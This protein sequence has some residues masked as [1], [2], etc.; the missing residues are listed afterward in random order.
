MFKIV[1]EE[2]L[3]LEKEIQK[4]INQLIEENKSFVFKAGAGAG[5]TYAL[6]EALR[7]LLKIK[8]ESLQYCNQK[9]AV[10]TFTNIATDEIKE[11]IGSSNLLEISTIHNRLWEIIR[12]YKKELVTIHLG[13]LKTK[14]FE[15]EESINNEKIMVRLSLKK[16]EEFIH[17]MTE[18]SNRDIFY[19]HYD[20]L[21]APAK[22]AYHKLFAA[23][24]INSTDILRNVGNFRSLVKNIYR[25]EKYKNA[26][27]YI[28]EGKAG[29]TRVTYN[30]K[31]SYDRL[32]RMEISHDTLLSYSKEM[33]ANYEGLQQIIINKYP[34]FFVD[35]YQDTKSEVVEIMRILSDYSARGKHGFFVGYFGD[36]AQNIYEYGIGNRLNEYQPKL[37]MISKELNR[38]SSQEI[39]DVANRVRNDDMQQKSIY[40][41]ASGGEVKFYFGNS[42]NLTDFI[43]SHKEKWE[44]SIENPLDCL[45]LTNRSVATNIGISN[46]Y[47]TIHDANLYSNGLGFKRLNEELLSKESEKLG[48]IQQ[49]ISNLFA[50]LSIIESG[51]KTVNN[52]L[53]TESI[54][55]DI[56]LSNIDEM[57]KHLKNIKGDNLGEILDSI[58]SEYKISKCR[59]QILINVTLGYDEREKNPIKLFKD[60]VRFILGKVKT[61][62]EKDESEDENQKKANETLKR[63]LS[64]RKTELLDWHDY[65]SSGATKDINFHTYHGTKGV[66]FQNVIIVMEN[67]FGRTSY[68]D[69]YF[70][71][72]SKESELEGRM[73]ADFEAAKNLLYVASSRAIKNLAIYYIDDIKDFEEGIK[74]VFGESMEYP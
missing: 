71:N 22:E 45:F 4:K 66:E 70:K 27:E 13:E 34:Y 58:N 68:F 67:K 21:A 35:E 62:D 16:R 15:I 61:S 36:V 20:D 12:N 31:N 8:G 6:I 32:E 64:I 7:Y 54:K 74:D 47:N 11:R 30:T 57:I 56:T 55:K 2:M 17:I 50:L 37:E 23:S 9:I 24:S 26:I 29:Y 49:K 48:R 10:I 52:I 19:K 65:R 43:E 46:L 60:D 39:I 33:I 73:L 72:R 18:K 14:L 3:V 63:L 41:D 38:R 42:T 28:S 1:N 53:V 40:E 5:K 44:V 59:F 25:S 69:S 51:D